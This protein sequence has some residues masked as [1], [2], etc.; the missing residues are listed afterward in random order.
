MLRGLSLTQRLTVFF[1]VLAAAIVL[2][3]GLVFIQ[4][5]ARH[6]VDLDRGTLQDK[7]RLIEDIVLSANSVE[8]TK[9]RLN[10]ALSH[11]HGLYVKVTDAQAGM[12]YQSQGFEAPAAA[13]PRPTMPELGKF[14]TPQQWS[15]GGREF[16]ALDFRVTPAY[17][18]TRSL[19]VLAAIDTA[20]HDHFL[21]ELRN[22]LLLYALLAVAVSG[23][24]G[25]LAAR[26]GL[27]PLRTMRAKA[28]AVS[29]HQFSERMPVQAVPV[30]MADLAAELNGMMD[31]LQDE[32]RRLS[33]FSSDLAHELRT[34]IS[35]LLTQ[36]QVALSAKRDSPTY[37]NI[38]ASNAEEL[39]RMARMVSDML[40]LAKAERGMALLRRERFATAPE[41]QA[42][43]EFYDAVAE[44]KGVRLSVNGDGEIDGDRLMFRRAIGNLLSNAVRH[45]DP[46][47]QVAVTIEKHPMGVYLSVENAADDIDAAAL[48]RLFDRFFRADPSRAHPASEG[49]GLGLSI[50]KAIVQAHG[51]EIAVA[52]QN[53]RVRFVIQLPAPASS[54]YWVPARLQSEMSTK[55]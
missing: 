29:G 37:R 32:Y 5:T 55:E 25:W 39:E 33:E 40:F 6:F 47:S 26:Q 2:G 9:W 49:A 31:R 50:A 1:T 19:N 10:E 54:G 24:L 11:H 28:A 36:T 52:S 12:L 43:L 51:G 21:A 20:H 22:T 16:R 48:P 44:E 14:I 38:L 17:D 3:L 18:K 8:D 41:V 13:L 23:V 7:R 45:G 4:A 27:A 15:A 34:P 30:E 53:R 42:L 35:N 46:G